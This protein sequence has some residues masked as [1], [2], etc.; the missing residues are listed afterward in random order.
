MYASFCSNIKSEKSVVWCD[1]SNLMMM[2]MKQI[3]N[4]K[5]D[6]HHPKYPNIPDYLYVCLSV[7]G[8][9]PAEKPITHRSMTV[10][11]L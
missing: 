10:G 9:A 11:H 7:C 8:D 2:K 6:Y 4:R 3:P 1:D 5:P